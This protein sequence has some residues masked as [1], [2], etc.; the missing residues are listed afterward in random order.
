[1]V[2]EVEEGAVLRK[3]YR[4]LSVIG[5][6]GMGKV[7]KAIHLDLERLVAIKVLHAELRSNPAL[8]ERFLREGRAAT[9][10]AGEN[11][12]R[13]L[14][15]DR[16]EDG[17]PYL[18]MEFLK[19]ADLST[20][21]DSGKPLQLGEAVDYVL[22]ACSAIAKAHASGIIH[23]DIKPANLFLAQEEDGTSRIKVLDF[24]ISKLGASALPGTP[25]HEPAQI[26]LTH[27]SLVMGSAEFMSPEQMLSARD[28]DARSDIWALGVVL[29]ELLTAR[30][31]FAG[32]TLPQ[33]CALILSKPPMSPRATRPELPESVEQVILRCLAKDPSDRYQTVEQLAA[34]LRAVLSDGNATIHP[35]TTRQSPQP[36]FRAPVEMAGTTVLPST[37]VTGLPALPRERENH[38]TA[39]PSTSTNL[40]TDPILSKSGS[41]RSLGVAGF[42]GAF[43]VCAGA[44][45]A[46]TH[47]R[48]RAPEQLSAAT[49][50]PAAIVSSSPVVAVSTA[51]P[52]ISTLTVKSVTTQVPLPV[53]RPQEQGSSSPSSVQAPNLPA[54]HNANAP[55]PPKAIERPRTVQ[56]SGMD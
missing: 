3:K 51:A 15:V 39:S 33:V 7:L 36:S 13:I 5:R 28:V 18:V 47:H 55:A 14:D 29:Y 43:A 35:S 2:D 12:A 21:R 27:T 10:I 24:G 53:A 50:A 22:Q 31:P 25:D 8:V 32:E 49:E 34:A 17:T 40:A 20:V 16:L 37:P 1:M 19:G 54:P 45:L 56:T 11:V 52:A 26:S 38:E 41:S 9:R 23:R 46:I 30:P 4:I 44:Y 48:A 6:G 42:V